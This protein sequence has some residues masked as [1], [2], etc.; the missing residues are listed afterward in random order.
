[1]DAAQQRFP[2]KVVFVVDTTDTMRSLDPNYYYAKAVDDAIQRYMNSN[3]GNYSFAVIGYDGRPQVLTASMAGEEGFTRNPALLQNAMTRLRQSNGCVGTRCRDLPGALS[4]ASSLITGDLTTVPKGELARTRYVV[5]LFAG[6]PP[7]PRISKCQCGDVIHD[8]MCKMP[9]NNIT[10]QQCEQTIYLRQLTALVNQVRGAGAP[11]MRVHT[12]Y[13]RDVRSPL[14]PQEETI[15]L[16]QRLSEAGNGAFDCRSARDCSE[17]PELDRCRRLMALCPTGVTSLLGFSID[18]TQRPFLIKKLI[19]SNLNVV[20]TATGPKLDSDGDGL[21]DE[22][23]MALGTRPDLE[24]TD[25]DGIGDLVEVRLGLDPRA[26]NKAPDVCYGIDFS[27]LPATPLPDGDGDFINDCEERLLGTD[28]TLADTDGDG[29][30]DG[31]ELRGGTNYLLADYLIPPYDHD[32]IPNGDEVRQH[33]APRADDSAEALGRAYQYLE[34]NE[35]IKALPFASQ[36]RDISGVAV[37]DISAGATPGGG[38]LSFLAGPPAQLRWKDAGDCDFGPPVT[39][40]PKAI[41]QQG[42]VTL[43]LDSFSTGG[44]ACSTPGK[45]MPP[46]M[47]DFRLTV[48]VDNAAVLPPKNVDETIVVGTATRAC[49]RYQVR[50]ISLLTPVPDQTPGRQ[51]N[52]NGINNV[53]VFFGQGPDGQLTTPGIFS[54]ALIRAR[55]A[56]PAKREPADPEIVLSQGD[57]LVLGG[58]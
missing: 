49:E 32:G 13:L 39:V 50:N 26:P 23:E 11:D 3:Q 30:P 6:G 4:L 18:S 35:G 16:L 5:V 19:V 45:P 28:P 46:A 37:L 38:T 54:T 53:Y 25:G 7:S 14:Q 34:D 51:T 15:E 33:T 29:L 24:D 40:D 42:G 47:S 55:Y 17:S 1:M 20:A 52:S 57:F 41:D 56:P 58:H 31:L 43:T 2:V 9:P 10:D 22:E 12:Y 48:R 36:P 8:P 27:L 44:T 21:T